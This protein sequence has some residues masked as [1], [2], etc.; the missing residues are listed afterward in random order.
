MQDPK[1]RNAHCVRVATPGGNVTDT[2]IIRTP[3]VPLVE[4]IQPALDYVQKI[5]TRF[6]DEPERYR[7][8]LDILSSRNDPVLLEKEVCYL[9]IFIHMKRTAHSWFAGGSYAPGS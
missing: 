8:F 7:N 2:T 1:V 4:D 5:K 6:S 3:S 9:L